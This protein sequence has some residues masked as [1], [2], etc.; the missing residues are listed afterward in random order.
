[1][2]FHFE[3]HFLYYTYTSSF[4]HVNV[5]WKPSKQD[6]KLTKRLIAYALPNNTF[7]KYAIR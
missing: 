1:M 2:L 3:G 6:S 5:F 7:I 4:S